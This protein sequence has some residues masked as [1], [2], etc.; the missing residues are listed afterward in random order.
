M[1]TSK[2]QYQAAYKDGYGKP[3]KEKDYPQLNF[4]ARELYEDFHLPVSV[5]RT[6]TDCTPQNPNTS[7]TRPR[8][9]ST[10]FPVVTLPLRTSHPCYSTIESM[11]KHRDQISLS[12][13]RSR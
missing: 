3:I 6:H 5:A 4:D 2:Q 7:E 10:T 12:V 13:L 9:V 1:Y 8:T 11:D